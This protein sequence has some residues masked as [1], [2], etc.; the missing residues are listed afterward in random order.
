MKFY[1]LYKATNVVIDRAFHGI[2]M[3]SD[4]FYGTRDSTDPYVGST[5]DIIADLRKYGRGAFVVEAIQA[6]F[7]HED[8][9]RALDR[10]TFPANSYNTNVRAIAQIG[11]K[12]ALGSV[13]T[14]E[15][16]AKLSEINT[17]EKNPFY[18]KKHDDDTK[19]IIADHRKQ[20]RWITNGFENRQIAKTD[21][22]PSGWSVGKMKKRSLPATHVQDE[23]VNDTTTA[24]ETQ[25]V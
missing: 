21:P 13:R 12:N 16:K 2:H 25:S 23:T 9:S 20:L 15:E 17:G 14:D 10:I 22:V 7:S 19:K 11:N 8:A 5:P 6:Y 18:G 24:Q 4:I 1:I 3:T